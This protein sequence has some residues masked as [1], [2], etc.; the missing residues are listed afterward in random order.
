[1]RPLVGGNALGTDDL[2][3]L[4]Q[5]I[6]T[7]AVVGLLARRAERQS[8]AALQGDRL[9][10]MGTAVVDFLPPGAPDWGHSRGAVYVGERKIALAL[11]SLRRSPINTISLPKSALV[12]NVTNAGTV[13]QIATFKGGQY[14]LMDMVPSDD[15]IE[16]IVFGLTEQTD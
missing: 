6:A 10:A 13:V 16:A 7:V 12:V 14:V 15:L 11:D 8:A 4:G 5:K 1:M 2:A 9:L 3:T